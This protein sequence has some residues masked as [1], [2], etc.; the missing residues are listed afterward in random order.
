MLKL[1]PFSLLQVFFLHEDVFL[2]N[3]YFLKLHFL[4]YI[5]TLSTTALFLNRSSQVAFA[6]E[7]RR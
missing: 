7:I 4:F 3:L 2:L 5:S 6:S 1:S